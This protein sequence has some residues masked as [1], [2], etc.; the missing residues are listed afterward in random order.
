[1][2]TIFTPMVKDEPFHALL[3]GC[4]I[5]FTNSSHTMEK[6][7][8]ITATDVLTGLTFNHSYE[9]EFQVLNASPVAAGVGKADLYVCRED[10]KAKKKS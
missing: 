2:K 4:H 8:T 5:R 6:A 3:S 7:T 1:M 10:R 9:G